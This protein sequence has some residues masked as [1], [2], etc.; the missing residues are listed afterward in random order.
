M[1]V[2]FMLALCDVQTPG[3]S[4]SNLYLICKIVGEMLPG[5]DIHFQRPAACA[6]G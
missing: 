6:D 5:R 1:E 4:I 3:A 2:G